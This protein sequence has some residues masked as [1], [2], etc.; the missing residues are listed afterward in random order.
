MKKDH[1]CLAEVRQDL[2]NED[3]TIKS[4][5]FD[6]TNIKRANRTG[7]PMTGQRIWYTYDHKKKD[8]NIVVKSVKTFVTHDFCPF[9]GL[10]Y[11]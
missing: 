9:C 4:V 3:E 10:K 5:R 8:G 11:P 6:C 7:V 1:N 2:M